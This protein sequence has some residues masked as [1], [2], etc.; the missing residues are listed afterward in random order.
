MSVLDPA[1]DAPRSPDLQI[2]HGD[3]VS[4]SQVSELADGSKPFYSLFFEDL[5]SFVHQKSIGG[6]AC[7][8]HASPQL[9]QLGEAHL[10][11]VADD[12]RVYIGDIQPR[13]ND[14]C[15]DQDVDPSADEIIHDLFQLGFFHLPVGIG[16]TGFRDQFLHFK[17]CP[18]DVI[19]AV[20]D[21][22]DL[23]LPGQF[24]DDRLSDKLLIVLHDEGLDRH[25]VPRGLFQNAHIPDP[26]HTHV[27]GAGDRCRRQGQDIH[28]LLHLFDLFLVGH[29]E[30]LLLIDHEQSQI[31]EC[32]IL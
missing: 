32:H 17:S 7:P 3:T 19:D 31:F 25:A 29:A 8:A 23:S 2:P 22:I 21:I 26:H 18:G 24:P 14:R 11:R 1:Q 28:I 20:V 16:H 12:D 27:E 15:R 6:A 13:F 30:A 9:V 10:F 4:A 5:S